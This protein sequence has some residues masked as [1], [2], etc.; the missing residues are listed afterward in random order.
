MR[1][2]GLLQ[3]ARGDLEG[4][5]TLM[6]DA[7]TRC[8]RQ[9]DTHSG[10]AP[11]C[12]MRCAPRHSRP[13][14]RVAALGDRARSFAGRW[15][16]REFPARAYLYQRDLGDPDAL[17]AARA[18]AVDVEN[19][20]PH[21][22]LE[23][24]ERPRLEQLIGV[25]EGG[26]SPMDG[27]ATL[28]SSG[29][30]RP[31]PA[32]SCTA[33]EPARMSPAEPPVPPS[34]SVTTPPA[35][36]TSSPPAATSQAASPSSKNPSN[37]PH[38]VHA[39]SR[40]A[41][42][43]RR[44]SSNARQR[45]APSPPGSAAAVP[46]AGTGTRSPPPPGRGSR[47]LTRHG[48]ATPPARSHIAPRPAAACHISPRNGAAIAP[49]T[50]DRP[51]DQ[52]HRHPHRPEPVD[53][54][55]RPVQRIDHPAQPARPPRRAP[56]PWKGTSGRLGRQVPLRS[57]ARWPGPPRSPS[58][59]AALWLAGRR[60]PAHPA[61]LGPHLHGAA[62]ISRIRPGPYGHGTLH[63]HLEAA[64]GTSAASFARLTR[65]RCDR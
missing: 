47:A 45:R 51:V 5:S 43:G 8:L 63:E 52:G 30:T 28:G 58:R 7:L 44:R 31:D 34:Q 16:M 65:A 21:G 20:P 18:L 35:S 23:A 36:R 62:A 33:R 4:G 1:G 29:A 57:P 22:M 25:A 38:A 46:C 60:A 41:A 24:G 42:P 17:E 61:P 14:I 39:R 13:S 37:T 19:P 54:V 59:P 50:G 2:I 3:A 27:R 26:R 10:S 15:G 48:A 55:R 53:E 40:H 49:A 11:T 6:E 12:W 64:T 56:R 9:R 32:A